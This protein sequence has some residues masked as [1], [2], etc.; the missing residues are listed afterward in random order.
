MEDYDGRLLA[1]RP[2]EEYD[3]GTTRG[4]TREAP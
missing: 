1:G 4:S 2:D 3:G